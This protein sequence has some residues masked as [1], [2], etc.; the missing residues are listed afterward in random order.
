MVEID[1]I[2]TVKIVLYLN[3]I[4]KIIQFKYVSYH[5]EQCINQLILDVIFLFLIF[6][7]KKEL[8]HKI[9]SVYKK[10]FIKTHLGNSI[11]TNKLNLTYQF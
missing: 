4:I 8:I 2:I 3:L 11:D 10:Y 6:L 5:K 9:K 1:L 7:S